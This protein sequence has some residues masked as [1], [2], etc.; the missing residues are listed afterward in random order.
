MDPTRIGLSIRAL[1]RR[2]G[3]TQAELARRAGCSTSQISRIERGALRN[4]SIDLIER[5]LAALGARLSIRVLW[6]G[7]E[8]DRLL[9]RDHAVII[10]AMLGL[11]GRSGWI[12][13]PESTFQVRGERGSIDILAWHRG[14]RIV[15]VIE[16]K[17][18][19]PDV[20][21][22]LSGVDRKTRLAPLL[23]RERGW[24]PVA[25][26]TILALPDDRTA[27][28]RVDRFTTTFRRALPMRT[29]ALKRWLAAPDGPAAGI[30]FLSDL[31]RVQ[32]RQRVRGPVAG[33]HAQGDAAPVPKRVLAP[34]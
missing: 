34:N 33:A 19:V 1:R 12:A 4:A 3:W 23:A 14:G 6:Q 25:V 18:V 10:E 8:L 21:A 29:T 11:L 5:I 26:A 24:D 22:T 7:E 31:P 9:D 13:V 27:R 17:S 30:L 32:G 16:V 28:R 15:L 20:Q 2:R